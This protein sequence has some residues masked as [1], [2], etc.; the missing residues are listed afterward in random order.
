MAD[1][2][3]SLF[4]SLTESNFNDGGHNSVA[5]SKLRLLKYQTKPNLPISGIIIC[6]K[7]DRELF[8]DDT[9]GRLYHKND[10]SRICRGA[11]R[12]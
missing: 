2:Q 5:L 11:D 3:Y 9:S 1:F 10:G 8:T 12:R 4:D 7:C 6:G